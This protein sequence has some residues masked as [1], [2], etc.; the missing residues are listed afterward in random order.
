MLRLSPL[1]LFNKEWDELLS[2]DM[3]LLG[4]KDTKDLDWEVV[5]HG[6]WV[7]IS[8]VEQVGQLEHGRSEQLLVRP[9]SAGLDHLD[10]LLQQ[11]LGWVPVKVRECENWF[12]YSDVVSLPD[13][14]DG[15]SDQ[16]G[17]ERDWEGALLD[18]LDNKHGRWVSSNKRQD[19]VEDLL[20]GLHTSRPGLANNLGLQLL[21]LRKRQGPHVHSQSVD[22][23]SQVRLGGARLWGFVD[24]AG[25][26]LDLLMDLWHDIFLV[27]FNDNVVWGLSQGWHWQDWAH[28]QK[29][30][31]PLNDFLGWL[32]SQTAFNTWELKDKRPDNPGGVWNI[33]AGRDALDLQQRHGDHGWSS[34]L[35]HGVVASEGVLRNP[36]VGNLANSE[37]I[38][39]TT[40]ID[41]GGGHDL[42]GFNK[43]IG[44]LGLGYFHK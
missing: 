5:D 32:T 35:L 24:D 36:L 12:N 18:L 14:T 38:Q 8:M 17:Q 31:S 6:G 3:G 1:N 42:Q 37:L 9:D 25:H 15:D 21:K 41:V 34:A 23:T 2:Q 26:L 44:P 27:Q 4:S 39:L 7:D 13:V 19:I 10:Q 28:T 16:L 20:H 40:D 43:V 29:F 22:S 30:L 11:F 33:E